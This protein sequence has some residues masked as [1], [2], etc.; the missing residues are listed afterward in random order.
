MMIHH[1]DIGHHA[2]RPSEY[3]FDDKNRV[4]KFISHT[5]KDTT[6]Y[7]YDEANYTFTNIETTGRDTTISK[8][9]F[10]KNWHP[11]KEQFYENLLKIFEGNFSI[12]VH[13]VWCAHG[14]TALPIYENSILH[15]S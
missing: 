1:N 15:P 9:F 8:V 7:V 12:L 6:N 3:I 11:I 4:V 13:C 14:V 5:S 10:N 2:L